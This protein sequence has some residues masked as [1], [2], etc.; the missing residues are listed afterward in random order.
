M[1]LR[2]VVPIAAVI[3]VGAHVWGGYTEASRIQAT[4]EADQGDTV[5]LG[6]HYLCLSQRQIEILRS[7][8]REHEGR[9]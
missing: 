3:G 9:V 2:W 1:K 8:K 4:C 7:E 5:I 6:Q